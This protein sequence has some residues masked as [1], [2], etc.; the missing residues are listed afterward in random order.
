MAI[1]RLPTRAVTTSRSTGRRDDDE[2]IAAIYARKSTEQAGVAEDNRSVTRQVEHARVYA[3]QKGWAVAEDHVY[4]DDGVS[5]A[6][7]DGR[8]PGLAALLNVLTPRPPFHVLVMPEESRLG[9]EQ[10]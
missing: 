8:R 7:F 6:E 1:G 3:Q 9:R 4:V 5:G 10:F 2:M